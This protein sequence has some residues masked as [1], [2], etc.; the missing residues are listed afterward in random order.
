MKL[1]EKKRQI[2]F[3]K[4]KEEVAMNRQ[5]Q[6]LG[7]AAFLLAINKVCK[8]FFHYLFLFNLSTIFTLKLAEKFSFMIF[9]LT[10]K[11]EQIKRL[12]ICL[13]FF[14]FIYIF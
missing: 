4:R 14:F 12:N 1:E 13:L 2:E 11:F 7:K 10:S 5:L 6:K 9:S 3:D 8:E